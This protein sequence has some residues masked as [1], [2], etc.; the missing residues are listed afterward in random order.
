[1]QTSAPTLP[2]RELPERGTR[3]VLVLLLAAIAVIVGLLTLHAPGAAAHGHGPGADAPAAGAHPGPA[4]HSHAA[5]PLGDTASVPDHIHAASDSGHLRA[6]SDPGHLNA[7]SGLGSAECPG[8][9]GTHCCAAAACL[10]VLA[11]LSVS[12]APGAA[13]VALAGVTL[14]AVA[15]F[16]LR[17]TPVRPPSLAQLSTLRI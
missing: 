6:A 11:L 8:V 15:A 1:M 7:G 3:R 10:P 17:P 13:P 5:V 12:Q 4:P 9:G 14:A 2:R 16:S